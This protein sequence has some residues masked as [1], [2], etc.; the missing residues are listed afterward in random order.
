[1]AN[2]SESKSES[3]GRT[4]TKDTTPTESGPEARG[5]KGAATLE[6]ALEQQDKLAK[7][8][9][10]TII[11]E[12]KAETQETAAESAEA[13]AEA[14]AAL[15]ERDD[16]VYGRTPPTEDELSGQSTTNAAEAAAEKA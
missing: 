6:E 12:G 15:M 13:Q 2:K 1:M 10:A 14:E 16:E 9:D 5:Q 3:E 4:P 11:S 8:Q 7:Q